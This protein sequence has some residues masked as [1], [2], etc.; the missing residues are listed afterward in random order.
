MYSTV[1]PA[2]A[3]FASVNK[4]SDDESC[5]VDAFFLSCQA[6]HGISI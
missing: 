1:F 2:D 3:V 6:K 5:D 4:R